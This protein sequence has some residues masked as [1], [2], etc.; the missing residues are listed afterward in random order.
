MNT[1][2]LFFNLQNRSV[3]IIGG[4]EVAI[5][6]ATLIKSAGANITV[7]AKHIRD[8]LY[9][10]LKDDNHQ[11]IVKSYDKSDLTIN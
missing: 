8:E 1:L 3:L 10:L 4:G 9:H 5:R 6:K 11:L 7:V 2:P